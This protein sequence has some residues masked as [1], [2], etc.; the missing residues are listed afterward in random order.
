M[1]SATEI[2]P[3]TPRKAAQP[4]EP[5]PRRVVLQMKGSDAWKGW[6]D[7]MSKFFRTPTSTLVDHA[8]V[9]YAAEMGFEEEAPE[10]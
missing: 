4:P 7:R 1:S 3:K 9:R 10:R 2:M 8:L 5:G 6:L